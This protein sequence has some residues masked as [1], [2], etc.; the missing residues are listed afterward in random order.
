M[1]ISLNNL[2][3]FHF[4]RKNMSLVFFTISITIFTYGIKIFYFSYGMDT[5]LYIDRYDAYLNHWFSIS[6]FGEVFLKKL[7]WGPYTNIYL[8]NILA[9]SLFVLSA[10][11]MCYLFSRI[12]YI[13]TNHFFVFTALFLTNS[14]FVP[15]FYFVLQNFEFTLGIF[16]V[17]CSCLL[18]TYNKNSKT[19]RLFYRF[20]SFLM[21]TLAIA[22]YQTFI[23]F[24]IAI[25]VAM[26]L[27]NIQKYVK[28]NILF[29]LKTLLLLVLPFVVMLFLSTIF[30]FLLNK[31]ILFYLGIPNANHSTDMMAWQNLGLKQGLISTYHSLSDIILK[32]KDPTRVFIYNFSSLVAIIVSIIIIIRQFILDK[33]SAI[34]VLICFLTLF[35]SGFGIVLAT[36]T[37][38]LPRTMVPQFPFIL[39]FIFFYAALTIESKYF[40]SLLYLLIIFFSFSQ[41]K[42][43]SN[44]L[45]SEQMTFQE[46]QRKMQKIDQLITNLQLEN[47]SNYKLIIIGSSNSKNSFNL[48]VYNELIGCSMFQFGKNDALGSFYINE[49]IISL[50][51]I[52]GMIYQYPEQEEYLDIWNN[53]TTLKDSKIDFGIEVIDRYI[54]INLS[55]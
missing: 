46:D 2:Q 6:R 23:L 7:L 13:R 45:Q 44:L 30:Y 4:L 14:L 34:S 55:E 24:F 42:L 25:V 38:P 52:N 53:R 18:L 54:V 26:S 37:V 32:P 10:L 31:L 19:I 33:K 29:N 48:N 41:L 21:L 43:S 28:N 50:M 5:N 11:T 49:N 39:S 17:V 47:A 9:L 40:K 3:F 15:Q 51:R 36:A 1:N 8:L 20:L 12:I 16:L 27:L 22:I 35:I